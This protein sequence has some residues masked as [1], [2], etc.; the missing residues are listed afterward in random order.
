MAMEESCD[1]GPR[2]SAGG[3][4]CPPGSGGKFF[5]GQ[6]RGFSGCGDQL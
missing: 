3:I 6:W 2:I 4:K 1:P 5:Y